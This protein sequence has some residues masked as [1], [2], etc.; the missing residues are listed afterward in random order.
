[1]ERTVK[2]KINIVIILGEREKGG[3]VEENR[4]RQG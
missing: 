2:G 1:M 3:Q 4:K